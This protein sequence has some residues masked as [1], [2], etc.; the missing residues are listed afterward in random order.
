MYCDQYG[1]LSSLLVT[2]ASC[3]GA[4]EHVELM[5]QLLLDRGALVDATDHTRVTAL[6]YATEGPRLGVIDMLLDRGANPIFGLGERITPLEI[7]ARE[8]QSDVLRKFLDVMIARKLKFDN[9]MSLL[10]SRHDD[11]VDWIV[12]TAKALTQYHWRCMYPV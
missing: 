1:R 3:T 10:P 9:I 8:F 12:D 5:I 2:A 11:S 7:A 6:T 4:D